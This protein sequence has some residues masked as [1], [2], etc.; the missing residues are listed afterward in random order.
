MGKQCDWATELRQYHFNM[1]ISA[2]YIL[3]MIEASLMQSQFAD[4]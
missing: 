2:M 3:E 1:K 4:L